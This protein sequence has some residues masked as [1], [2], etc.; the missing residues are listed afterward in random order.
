MTLVQLE[1]QVRMLKLYA[2]TVTLV[3]LMT[4]IAGF[5]FA[6]RNSRFEEIDV[7]RINIVDKD[8][9]LKIVLSN[10]ERQ[11]PGTIDGHAVP[12]HESRGPGIIF[13]NDRGDE[14]G[15]LTFSGNQKVGKTSADA[16]LTFD[17]FRQDQTVG[18]QYIEENGER[19]AGLRVWDRPDT[20]LWQTVEKMEAIQKLPEGPEKTAALKKLKEAI[21]RGEFGATRITVGTDARKVARVVLSDGKGKP[22]IRMSVDDDGRSSIEFLNPAGKVVYRL[23]PEDKLGSTR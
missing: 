23:P 19:F 10:N 22:C 4:L 20:S 13:F 2:G 11:H 15:G 12:R 14:C 17:R 5:R 8:G 9:K 21:A 1:K 3:L 6:G 7:E 18:I 16:S